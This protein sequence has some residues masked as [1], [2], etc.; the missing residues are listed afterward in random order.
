MVEYV[1]HGLS[2]AA[3]ES[4]A[5]LYSPGSNP[6]LEELV[7]NADRVWYF[8]E[9]PRASARLV[10]KAFPKAEKR[11]TTLEASHDQMVVETRGQDH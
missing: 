8:D 4:A 11:Q 6:F 9:G 5:L 10:T 1:S 2:D 3:K 7:R